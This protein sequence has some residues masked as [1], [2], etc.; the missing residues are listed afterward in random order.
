MWSAAMNQKKMIELIFYH[1]KRYP[2]M[3]LE[4]IYKL[5]YQS[6]MGPAHILQ[7]KE[8]AYSYLKK[9]FESHNESYETGLYVDISLDHELVRLNIPVFK[10]ED[11]LDALFEMMCETQRKMIPDKDKLKHSWLELG[12][13]IENKNFENFTLNQWGKFNKI[14]CEKDF[15]HLSHS[16]TYKN[17]YRPSYRIVLR[18]LV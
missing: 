12:L 8:L 18:K 1:L 5:L 6:V 13:L 17:L 2:A 4:D 11:S 14:L 10:K 3:E 7:N 16:A 9:E 15:P